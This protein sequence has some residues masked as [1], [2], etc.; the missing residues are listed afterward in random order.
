MAEIVER[1][2]IKA[3]SDQYLYKWGEWARRGDGVR[4]LWYPSHSAE[5]NINRIPGAED[6]VAEYDEIST[7]IDRAIAKLPEAYRTV[8]AAYY[9][10]QMPLRKVSSHIGCSVWSVRLILE[11]IHGIVYIIIA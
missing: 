1:E 6:D 10:K 5:Q 7:L 4:R 3:V 2:V 8:A 9:I 11:T